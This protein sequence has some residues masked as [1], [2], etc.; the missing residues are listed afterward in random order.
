[1]P[2]TATR[3]LSVKTTVIFGQ[4][5]VSRHTVQY[6]LA[7]RAYKLLSRHELPANYECDSCESQ[8]DLWFRKDGQLYNLSEFCTVGMVT[9]PGP[10][11]GA[12]LASNGYFVIASFEGKVYGVHIEESKPHGYDEV[13]VYGRN[14]GKPVTT[15]RWI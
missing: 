8:D 12:Q 11:G 2:L 5:R 6:K 10:R 4:K 15:G 7:S 1:M 9:L 13:E 14:T 3:E